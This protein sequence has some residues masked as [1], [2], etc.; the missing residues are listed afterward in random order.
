MNDIIVSP[1]ISICKT[2]P[3]TGY[4]YGCGRTNEEKIIW[5][6]K[7]TFNTW[8]VE[9]LTII[10]ERLSG[11]QKDAFEKSYINKKKTGI[12]LIKKK[13]MENVNS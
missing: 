3:L 1:C 10:K 8:K 7:K 5:N 9:N 12:S 13:S 11:W 2:D 6:D 4:C